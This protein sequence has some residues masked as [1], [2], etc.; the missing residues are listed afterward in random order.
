VPLERGYGTNWRP[1]LSR[2]NGNPEHEV[3]LER[4][5]GTNWRPE[6][7]RENGNPE[8]EVPLERGYGTNWKPELSRE[9]GNPEHEV[10]L[11]RGYGTNWRPELYREHGNPEHE[12]PLERGYGTNWRPELYHEHGNPED[13]RT[14]V[15]PGKK[16]AYAVELHY[17][18]REARFFLIKSANVEGIMLAKARGLWS[19]WSR[20]TYIL[21]E[22]VKET[23][24]VIL[25]FTPMFSMKFS[26]FAR[27]NGVARTDL[28][29]RLAPGVDGIFCLDWISRS[30]LPY[31]QTGHVLN[32]FDNFAPVMCGGEGYEIDHRAGEQLCELFPKDTGIDL[33]SVMVKAQKSGQLLRNKRHRSHEQQEAMAAPQ[34][35]QQLRCREEADMVTYME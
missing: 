5:Y 8:H 13:G 23:R 28:P 10:P 6:L 17:L 19:T 20:M 32:E 21:N 3:P 22:A 34:Y 26:G 7:S 12:V 31:R 29:I 27:I 16:Y 18:C 25:I 24:T 14:S 4:G 33:T 1:E 11:E 2:E 15:E 35:M 30:D 9:H